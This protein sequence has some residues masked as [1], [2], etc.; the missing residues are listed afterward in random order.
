MFRTSQAA[1][2]VQVLATGLVR[3]MPTATVDATGL[4]S[5]HPRAYSACGRAVLGHR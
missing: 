1:L 4:E 5:R 2:V 3:T